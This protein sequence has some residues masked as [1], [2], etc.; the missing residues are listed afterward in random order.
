MHTREKHGM[1][2]FRDM[3]GRHGTRYVRDP[4]RILHD[5]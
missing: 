5:P 3:H 2:L 4:L 1:A